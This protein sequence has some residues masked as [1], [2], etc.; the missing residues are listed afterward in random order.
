MT[1]S[2][3]RGLAV[4]AA[5]LFAAGALAPAANAAR[6]LDI[7][8]QAIPNTGNPQAQQVSGPN[9][10]T[11]L[12]TPSTPGD[13]NPSA[14]AA[15]GSPGDPETDLV[16]ALDSMG[17]AA[18]VND[19]GK[20]A[21]ARQLALDILEGNAI[22]GKAYSGMPLLNWNSPA[23]I[24][25]VPAGG[26]VVVR[27]VR[28]DEHALSDT[29]LLSFDDPNQPY[30]ITFRI[31]ELGTTF[32]SALTPAP[33]LSQ[34]GNVIGGESQV[35]TPLA[36]PPLAMGTTTSNRFTPNGGNEFTRLAV[37]DV[38]VAMPPPGVTDEVLEPDLKPG[39]ETLF[40][41]QR[42]NAD[43]INAAR[44]AFGF[45]STT[46]SAAEKLAAID[47]LADVSPEKELWG[48][49]RQLRPDAP[50]F[51]DAAGVVAGGDR[52]LVGAMRT[53]SSPAAGVARDVA[54]DVNVDF[55]N[56]ETY[57]F[58][59][60]G[61]LP[62]PGN[63]N[64]L[65]VATT[66][67][68]GF[69]HHL[70]GLA[71]TNASPAGSIGWGQFS[72]QPVSSTSIASGASGSVNVPLPSGTFAVW[73]GDPDSGDQAG[74]L[75]G[76]PANGN[77]DQASLSC[78][79]AFKPVGPAPSGA[80]VRVPDQGQLVGGSTLLGNQVRVGARPGCAKLDWLTRTGTHARVGL[81]NQTRSTV[82]KCLGRPSGAAKRRGDERWRYG[83]HLIVHLINRRVTSFSLRTNHYVAKNQLGV[84]STLTRIRKAL[85]RTL[86]D[87]RTRVYRAVTP[88]FTAKRKRYAD[89][90]VHYSKKGQH[91]VTRIDAKLVTR[92]T[93][94]S[95]GRRLAA[96]TR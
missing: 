95:I 30:T 16:G 79:I 92:K 72:W 3:P 67:A 94:D 70:V 86:L 85:G 33:L 60:N 61:P 10:V 76:I 90:R 15:L 78:P 96:R 36:P 18:A 52:S 46:P 4:L 57:L 48:D 56:N 29:W 25:S 69:T 40:T 83:K 77:T 89:V 63:G 20:A 51:L 44:A 55:L 47:K 88:G 24:K 71:L 17:A 14:L 26:N 54:A 49:L 58:R 2:K 27:E 68:D 28:W 50:G 5:S 62:T 64:N 66:N 87:R 80:R 34:G 93:L 73:L 21:S 23:K 41:L 38:T 31:A 37:Q 45:S 74:G 8:G 53:R 9:V 32:G 6:L 59:G 13:D 42:T 65:R 43:H 1:H 75:C 81:L 12:G 35:L 91:K 84:G 19:R 22:G 39:S 82:L 7:G 11:K